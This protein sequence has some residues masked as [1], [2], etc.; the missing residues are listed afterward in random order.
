MD[1]E[2]FRNLEDGDIIEAQAS[3]GDIY[4]DYH[5]HIVPFD[6]LTFQSGI[7][8]RTGDIE[9]SPVKRITSGDKYK[10]ET[11]D[12]V[13]YVHKL[14]PLSEVDSLNYK[15][16]SRKGRDLMNYDISERELLEKF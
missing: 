9:E 12:G 3:D 15:L 8:F 7:Y 13:K 16:I 4:V 5:G 11:I 1:L 10:V 6:S 2:L 14:T